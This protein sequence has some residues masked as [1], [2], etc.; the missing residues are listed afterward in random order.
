MKPK[1]ASDVLRQ[2]SPRKTIGSAFFS[3]NRFNSLRD[4]SPSLSVRSISTNRDRSVSAKRKA[5]D[6]QPS[7]AA[8][9]GCTSDMFQDDNTEAMNI[10][11]AKIRSV[12]DDA[13][14][15]LA[16]HVA[17]PGIIS[18][19]GNIIDALHQSLDLQNDIINNMHTAKPQPRQ[20]TTGTPA[21]SFSL[22][23]VA[24]KQ[25]SDAAQSTAKSG[26]GQPVVAPRLQ[27]S[28]PPVDNEEVDPI[29]AKFRETVKNAEKS[30][31]LLN[32]DLGR[33]PIMNQNTIST[34]AT[35]ALAAM[36]ANS[37][38]KPGV[39]PSEEAVT[40]ID[41]VLSM[42]KS[43]QFYGK[44]T[45]TYKNNRDP[46][47]GSFCTIPVRYEFKDKD[48]R[49]RAETTLRK[50]CNVNCSTPYPTILRETIRQVVSHVKKDYPNSQVRVNVDLKNLALRVARR[51]P[52]EEG[53]PRSDWIDHTRLITL[54]A[55]VFDITARSV[56][57][58]FRVKDLP[59]SPSKSASKRPASGN[60]VPMQTDAEVS[61][62]PAGRLSRKDSHEGVQSPAK[63][64][65]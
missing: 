38:G 44:S 12:C 32:L 60:S 51:P 28:K 15:A 18:V 30:S 10:K 9:T 31:L 39:V 35:G 2:L 49:I 37:E 14:S 53:Q 26:S 58:N 24:K 57:D 4:R 64:Q 23:H 16:Q 17:D 50:H 3:G 13:A 5:N 42:V 47:S 22:G 34:K 20:P 55:E 29:V 48:T 27:K 1:S 52:A 65:P 46:K 7:Y 59:D 21:F 33:V 56:P 54:P 62:S 11:L 61:Q 25:R 19:F 45:K 63:K 8:I 36:A 40:A 6:D 43:M 41:D